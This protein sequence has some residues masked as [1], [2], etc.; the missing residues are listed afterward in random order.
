MQ[1]ETSL[2]RKAVSQAHINGQAAQTKMTVGFNSPLN[3]LSQSKA[4][5]TQ[6]NF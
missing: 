2:T 3:W 5:Q 4:R 1:E 6:Q